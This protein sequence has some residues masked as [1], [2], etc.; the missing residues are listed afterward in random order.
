M[1]RTLLCAALVGAAAP[2]FFARAAHAGSLAIYAP[3]D[4]GVVLGKQVI[5][6]VRGC[7]KKAAAFSTTLDGARVPLEFRAGAYKRQWVAT[8][9]LAHEGAH[10]LAFTGKCRGQ[11]TF[12]S[13]A[14]GTVEPA[15]RLAGRYMR[16]HSPD[17]LGWDWGPAV[18]LYGLYK[19]D[20][21]SSYVRG[22]QMS[23]AAKGI[24]APAKNDS[25]PAALTAL[26]LLRD[27]NDDTGLE[28][29]AKVARYV[30]TEPRNRLGAIN[31]LGHSFVGHFF[32]DSIWVD[33]LM[34]VGV[35][36]AQWGA[37]FND[38]ALLDFAAAQPGLYASALQDPSTG[39]FRHAYK[40]KSGKTIPSSATFWLRGNG[41]VLAATADILSELPA[42]HPKRGEL[43]A[44]LKKTADGLAKFQQPTGL[45]DTIAN[46]PGAAYGETSGTALVAYAVAKAV[47][48]GW[49]EPSYLA[50]AKRAFA[51]V[52]SR[53]RSKSGGELSMPRISWFTNPGARF[54]YTITPAVS[55]MSY[56]VG[57]YLMAAA[58]LSDE[59]F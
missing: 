20:P 30:R 31:H 7:G 50:L 24:S 29:A 48:R 58:E 32:P 57:A 34:M 5:V 39:L 12:V 18:F 4:G 16:G 25:C 41:W 28:N 14:R 52:T 23:W 3:A 1:V 54:S 42:D 27:F 46:E 47:H 6:D 38:R 2:G 15:M 33:S 21:G 36:A 45:W 51:G 19:L 53:L 55:D 22:Y 8:L 11:T 10:T 59:E 37:H 9:P 26:G 17:T 40:V 35:F 49:L 13:H 56:G 43:I 44:L